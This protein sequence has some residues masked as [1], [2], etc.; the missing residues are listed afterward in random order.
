MYIPPRAYRDIA[1]YASTNYTY[2][3]TVLQGG[4]GGTFGGIVNIDEDYGIIINAYNLMDIFRGIQEVGGGSISQEDVALALMSVYGG[5][6]GQI[7]FFSWLSAIM[8][9]VGLLVV[10]FVRSRSKKEGGGEIDVAEIM[11]TGGVP[12]KTK[13]KQPEQL[14]PFAFGKG[15]LNPNHKGDGMSDFGD[16]VWGRLKGGKKS[17]RK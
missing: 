15:P 16:F 14:K 3:F 12:S 4:K 17:R 6:M 10:P 8:L 9:F 13:G 1:I 5:Q 7:Q 2:A 11:R